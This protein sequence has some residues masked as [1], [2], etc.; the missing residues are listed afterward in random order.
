L[1]ATRFGKA[2]R[3]DRP[4]EELL[5]HIQYIRDADYQQS[6]SP[7]PTIKEALSAYRRDSKHFIPSVGLSTSTGEEGATARLI[8][9]K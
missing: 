4:G 2:E 9:R 7:K 1:V 6:T 3:G 5:R 8:G